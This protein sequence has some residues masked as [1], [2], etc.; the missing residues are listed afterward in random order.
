MNKQKNIPEIRFPEFNAELERKRLGKIIYK[1]DKKNKENLDLPV[2]SI[3]NTKGFL[4]QAEQFEGRNSNDRGF[5]ISI[6]KIINKNTF[7]Y[8]PARI[9]VGSIGYS[10]DL[11]NILVSSLYVCFK[12]K[13]SLD[14][15]FLLHFLKTVSFNTS[16]L[17]YEEGGVRKYLFF[18]NIS[19]IPIFLPSIEEQ[20]RIA[21]F[22]SVTDKRLAQL[23]EKK[24][25]LTAYKKGMMQKIFSQE[26]RFKDENRGEFPDWEK[27][28]FGEVFSFHSTNSFSR[29]NLNYKAGFVKNI[30]YGDIHTKFNSHFETTKE[31]V[32]FI[33][34]EIE[35]SK[36]SK[37]NYCK[38]GDLIIADAS[39]DYEDVGKCIEIIELNNEKVLAGLH[40]IHA[41]PNSEKITIGFSGHLMKSAKIRLQIK[42]IAQG[43]KVLSISATR[44]SNIKISLP[45]I[46][47]Q[48]KI[49]KFLSGIDNKISICQ[50]KIE[51][52][53]EYKKSLLQK[54]FC[55]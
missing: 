37:I 19:K 18:D 38:E 7:A 45:S 55:V 49:A 14:D 43:T 40:T 30:H 36:I 48:T 17:R 4:P 6:Y 44:L 28:K 53:Q 15:I 41:R 20:K 21:S 13:E 46:S 29:D 42:V 25:L 50:S 33:N 27:K 8:N 2:Y 11:D 24:A 3:N 22:L 34:A 26:L 51:Q 31:F 5:D 23:K 35:L 52:T 9:N 39:E 10:F 1:T 47:E 54:M 12:T 32:P 16:I